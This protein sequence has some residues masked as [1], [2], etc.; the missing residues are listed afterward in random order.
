[1][2]DYAQTASSCRIAPTIT[3]EGTAPR[4]TDFMGDFVRTAEGPISTAA[5]MTDD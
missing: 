5:A 3:A 4:E 1:M 2:H